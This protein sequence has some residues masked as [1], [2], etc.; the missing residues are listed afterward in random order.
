M[1]FLPALFLALL[2][3]SSVAV[4]DALEDKVNAALEADIRTDAEKDRDRNRKPLETLQFFGLTD[5]MRV[6]QRGVTAKKKN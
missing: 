2:F 5:D 4:A 1:K 3:G 6:S